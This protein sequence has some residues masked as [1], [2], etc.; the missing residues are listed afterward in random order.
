MPSTHVPLSAFKKP[1][2]VESRRQTAGLDENLDVVKLVLQRLA[3]LGRFLAR[4]RGAAR[5]KPR[6]T[7]S[8]AFAASPLLA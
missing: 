4:R 8:N 7:V 3:N 1:S 2:F 6:W 5:A